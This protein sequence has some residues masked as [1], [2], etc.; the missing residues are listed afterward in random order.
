MMP[1]GG[2]RM[3]AHLPKRSCNN[4][5]NSLLQI[6]QN[7]P[8]TSLPPSLHSRVNGNWQLHWQNDGNLDYGIQPLILRMFAADL[9]HYITCTQRLRSKN[10]M[11]LFVVCISK[12]SKKNAHSLS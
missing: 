10:P 5:I 7:Q 2:G 8:G 11:P 9:R 6:Q 1:I 4:G 3:L 12:K